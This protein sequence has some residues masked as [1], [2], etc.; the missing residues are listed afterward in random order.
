MIKIAAVL[1]TLILI[2]RLVLSVYAGVSAGVKR[3]DWIEYAVNFNGS[4]NPGHDVNWARMKFL[5]LTGQKSML[6]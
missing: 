4:P 2:S 5:K 1:T 6:T 3:G